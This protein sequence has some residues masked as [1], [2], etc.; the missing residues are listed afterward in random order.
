MLFSQSN[1]LEKYSEPLDSLYTNY[2]KPILDEELNNNI[3]EDKPLRYPTLDDS[4]IKFIDWNELASDFGK[5]TLNRCDYETYKFIKSEDKFRLRS[6]IDSIVFSYPNQIINL[7]RK[8]QIEELMSILSKENNNEKLMFSNKPLCYKSHTTKKSSYDGFM[9]WHTNCDY[10]GDR[11][12]FVYNPD[13]KSSFFRYID[14]ETEEMVTEW[15]PKG[16]SLNH[17]VVGDHNNLTWHCVHTNSYRF[18]FGIR[19][20]GK[21]WSKRNMFNPKIIDRKR[22]L[23]MS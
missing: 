11:W 16:W 7:M 22:N 19:K 20:N 3:I 18:S 21:K 5:G 17:F 15:E 23:R 12:Y 9:G 14:S 4:M 13:E 2:I 1:K 6:H 10:P 8:N